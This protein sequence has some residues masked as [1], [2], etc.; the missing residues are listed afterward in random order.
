MSMGE[1][2]DM[3]QHALELMLICMAPALFSTLVL[4]ILIGLMQAI[5]QLQDPAV[6]FVP[7]MFIVSGVLF[8]SGN[9]ILTHLGQLMR[10]FFMHIAEVH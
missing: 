1:I 7:K 10:D 9:F 4:G 3:C 6:S 8:F 5:T 2:L